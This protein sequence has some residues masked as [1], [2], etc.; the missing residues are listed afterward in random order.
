MSVSVGRLVE[1]LKGPLQL[2]QLGEPNGHDREITTPEVASPGLAL[3]GYVG[4]F[5]AQRVQVLGETEVTFLATLRDEERLRI[6]EQLFSFPIPCIL[7]TKG[8]EPPSPLLELAG[9]AGVPVFRSPH[10]TN[11]LY[12]RVKPVLEELFAPNVA[13]GLERYLRATGEH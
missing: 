10:K 12:R 11:E 7:I 9:R 6:L 13:P 3:A 5:V 1:R 2:Q 8:L 4:R